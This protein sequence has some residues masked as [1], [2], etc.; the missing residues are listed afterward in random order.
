MGSSRMKGDDFPLKYGIVLL[1][2]NAISTARTI[3]RMY[4]AYVPAVA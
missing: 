3:P 1:K 4:M 2:S